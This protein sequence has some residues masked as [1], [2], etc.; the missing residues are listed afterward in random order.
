MTVV[1]Q[2]GWLQLPRTPGTSGSTSN[3]AKNLRHSLL[4]QQGHVAPQRG[5]QGPCSCVSPAVLA[6]HS[7]NALAAGRAP[8]PGSHHPSRAWCGPCP[9]PAA[10][11]T[12]CGGSGCCRGLPTHQAA[13]Q[14]LRLQLHGLLPCCSGSQGAGVQAERPPALHGWGAGSDAAAGGCPGSA[15]APRCRQGTLGA[16]GG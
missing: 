2:N 14:G 11:C 16:A 10:A 15:A 7:C 13:P 9:C 12:C 6:A 4:V 8:H 3:A 5:H 1:L